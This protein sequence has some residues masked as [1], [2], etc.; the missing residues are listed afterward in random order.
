M[1]ARALLD[2]EL[3]MTFRPSRSKFVRLLLVCVACLGVS[4]WV[5]REQP[6][7]GY[8][9]AGFCLLAVLVF[10]AQLMPGSSYLRLTSSG[11]TFCSLYRCHTV[12]WRHVGEFGVARIATKKLVG[13]N[14]PAGYKPVG[15][16]TASRA[17]S[18]YAAALPDTYGH[19]PEDLAEVMN[20]LRERYGHAKD[21]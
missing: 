9:G 15:L 10:A 3:P 14:L 21:I 1:S 19:T 6:G 8:S 11:F 17:L 20:S 2:A 12:E 13:W 5:A 4:L 16:A 18:G 7:V